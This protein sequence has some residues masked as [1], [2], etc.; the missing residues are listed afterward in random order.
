VF[1]ANGGIVID[2]R[3][4]V[5]HFKYEQRA[6]EAEYFAT[7][8]ENLGLSEV[9]IATQINEGEGDFRLVGRQILAGYGLRSDRQAAAEVAEFFQLPV[10]PLR[11]V[12]PRFYHLDTALAVLDERT[13]AYWPGAFDA[14]SLTTLQDLFPDAIISSEAEAALLGLNMVSDGRT[15]IM[16]P[17]CPS[18]TAAITDRG[19]AVVPLASDE[20]RKA[21]GGVKCCVLERHSTEAEAGS[22]DESVEAAGRLRMTG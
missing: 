19:F 15:V 18:L 22:L 12:D 8:L 2:D 7:A 11:L 13:V 21:G 9:R 16:A 17:G 3:A 10:V 6:P 1:T 5:P 20:L 4:L 14:P